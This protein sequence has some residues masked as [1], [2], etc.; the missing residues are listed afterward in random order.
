MVAVV[1]LRARR[2]RRPD[3][4]LGG[5]SAAALCCGLS[6]DSSRIYGQRL[7]GV[8]AGGPQALRASDPG[9]PQQAGH[10]HFCPRD[11]AG[12]PALGEATLLSPERGPS[13]QPQN[14]AEGARLPCLQRPGADV[15]GPRGGAGCAQA[16][17]RSWMCPGR[18]CPEVST[19]PSLS[20]LLCPRGCPAGSS[21][22]NFLLA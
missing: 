21:E 3:S 1:L 19:G 14:L 18:S 5:R 13:A 6:S 22:Y 9:S 12:T 11:A 16:T 15:P 8:E 20:S 2:G 10:P 4:C 17:G 7:W